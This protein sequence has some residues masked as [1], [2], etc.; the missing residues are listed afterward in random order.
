MS[1][2]KNYVSNISL[3][4]SY[5]LILLYFIV[6]KRMF[7]DIYVLGTAFLLHRLHF[8]QSRTFLLK[9]IGLIFPII[10]IVALNGQ[11]Y[12]TMVNP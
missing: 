5:A 11:A 9:R 12:E 4:Y 8:L 3:T 10:P 1:E 6:N 7:C 2:S